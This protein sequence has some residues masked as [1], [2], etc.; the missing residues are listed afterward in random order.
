[1]SAALVLERVP[2]EPEVCGATTLGLALA[3]ARR[4][5]GGVVVCEAACD[6]G[7]LEAIRGAGCAVRCRLGVASRHTRCV[8]AF[9]RLA[10][11]ETGGRSAVVSVTYAIDRSGQ[12]TR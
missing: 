11:R 8:R 12:S 10:A 9:R 2:R 3:F 7:A 5:A 4:S 1:V 6:A